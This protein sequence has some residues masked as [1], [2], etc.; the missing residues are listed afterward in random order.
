MSVVQALKS[1][2]CRPAPLSECA[3]AAFAALWLVYGDL[4]TSPLYTLQ[5]INPNHRWTVYPEAAIGVLSLILWA[6]SSRSP[7]S[8]ASS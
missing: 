7:S 6:L 8:T 1:G 2:P 5:A 3:R 4:G